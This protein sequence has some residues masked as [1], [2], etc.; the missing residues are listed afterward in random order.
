MAEELKTADEQKKHLVKQRKQEKCQ[1]DR[2]KSELARRIEEYACLLAVHNKLEN[3]ISNLEE[4]C[5]SKG[6]EAV[7]YREEILGLKVGTD[8]ISQ[9]CSLIG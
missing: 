4:Q 7:K 5:M 8:R 2:I 3:S 1:F 6:L 9:Y